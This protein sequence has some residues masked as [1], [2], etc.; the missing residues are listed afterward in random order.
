MGADYLVWVRSSEQASLLRWQDGT[1]GSAWQTVMPLTADQ[2]RFDPSHLGGQTDLYLPF[3]LLG[4]T[5]S[6]SLSV[7]GFA[8]EEPADGQSLQ[9]WSTLPVFNPVNSLSV[10]LWAGLV[11]PGVHF[12]LLHAFRWPRL[13][14]GICPSAENPLAPLGDSNL[15]LSIT[16]DPPGVDR[17]VLGQG[18]FWLADLEAILAGGQ[19]AQVD[20]LLPATQPIMNDQD[21]TYHVHLRNSGSQDAVGVS[22]EL[23]AVG[24]LSLDTTTV[25]VGDI[26]AGGDKE[27]S[28]TG[29][30]DKGLS[31]APV[32]LAG[33]AVFDAAHPPSGV[34]RMGLD[35]PPGRPGG[36]E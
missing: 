33:L 2:F 23:R 19:S 16:A 30:T 22:L 27:V 35:R 31:Q 28:F 15:E 4:L 14:D 3:E 24:Q 6:S 10:S 18:L 1:S 8:T 20:W 36:A 34:A 32:A 13:A 21:V 11:G 12:P 25:D 17:S 26:P 5:P 29:H 7:L 9:L